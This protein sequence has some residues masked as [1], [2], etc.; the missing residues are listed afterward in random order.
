MKYGKKK[1]WYNKVWDML[2]GAYL[3]FTHGMSGALLEERL[4]DESSPER[5]EAEEA[6][7]KVIAET[8]VAPDCVSA[9]VRDGGACILVK[10]DGDWEGFIHNS[11]GEA[12]DKAIEWLLL[13]GDFVETQ[14]TSDMNRAQRRSFDA[15]RRLK[16]GGPAGKVRRRG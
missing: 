5:S 14:N 6:V 2:V 4:A 12:A 3:W 8:D 1:R 10:T 11:Y 16:R 15:K 9:L 7:A 13:Q